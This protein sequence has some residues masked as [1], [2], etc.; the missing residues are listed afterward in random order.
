MRHL[1]RDLHNCASYIIDKAGVHHV[2]NVEI[3]SGFDQTLDDP[4]SKV[5][6]VPYP[7]VRLTAAS[8]KLP[9]YW[10]TKMGIGLKICRGRHDDNRDLCESCRTHCKVSRCVHT[11]GIHF[12]TRNKL[13]CIIYSVLLRHVQGTIKKISIGRSFSSMTARPK[14]AT[15][16]NGLVCGDHNV[17]GALESLSEQGHGELF[18]FFLQSLSCEKKIDR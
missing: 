11:G 4:V 7:D 17:P 12:C 16:R 5:F 10:L 3:K 8:R 6:S 18:S 9:Q 13:Q 1:T 14:H 15:G 2:S